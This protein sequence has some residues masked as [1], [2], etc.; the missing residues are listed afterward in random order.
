MNPQNELKIRP[1]VKAHLN[2][3]KDKEL[4]KL[5]QCL[6]EIAGLDA[7]LELNHKDWYLPEKQEQ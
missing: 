1:F 6:K 2:C 7:L 4:M 5:T 3:D